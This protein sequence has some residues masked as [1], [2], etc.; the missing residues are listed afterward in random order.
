[1]KSMFGGKPKGGFFDLP[2]LTPGD[3]AD[4][5]IVLMGIPEATPYTSVGS[6]CADAPAAI[7]SAFGLA[8]CT[9]TS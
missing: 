5:S 3:I 8:R 1:M 4:A 7:R 9:G 2:L 6:Y